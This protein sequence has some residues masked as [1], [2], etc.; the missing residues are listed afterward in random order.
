MTLTIE[1][2]GELGVLSGDL[3]SNVF[4]VA[5][6]MPGRKRWKERELHFELTR[7]NID[8]MR[9][10]LPEAEWKESARFKQVIDAEHLERDAREAK[11]RDAP[12]EAS[13]FQF[14][15]QPRDHQRKTFELSKD[16]P[17]FGY[18][19][20][21]GLG[22]TKIAIDVAAHLYANGKIDTMLITAPNGVHRQWVNEQLPAHMPDFIKT[23]A[24]IYQSNHTKKWLKE[25]NDTV[26]YQDGLR[27]FAFH[28]EAFQS[29]KGVSFARIALDTGRAIWHLDESVAIKTPGAKRTKNILKLAPLAPYRRILSGAPV[30]KGIED[31]F[32]QFKFLNE[33]I[34]GFRS[35]YTFRNYYCETA[36]IPGAPAGAVRIVGYK[37]VDELQQQIDAWSVRYEA[38]DCLDLPERVYKT[39]EV[40]WDKKQQKIYTDL[41][42]D[43]LA[44][45]GDGTLVTA[46]Q[47]IVR[48]LR[49]QQVLCGHTKDSEGNVIEVP[50]NRIKTVTEIM[51]EV[52]DK[53][54]IWA[55][56]HKDIDM[57][58]DALKEY[59]PVTWDG[60]T[61]DADRDAAKKAFIN[62]DDVRVFIGNPSAAGTGLDGL[63]HA[64]HTMIYY[65]NSFDASDR[66]QSEARL[67]RDGQ[68]GTVTVIDL[69]V[70]GTIDTHIR[71]ALRDKKT[72]SDMAFAID[73][74]T[75]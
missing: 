59:R 16:A 55:R 18:F 14:K 43:L 6:E 27:V 47:I 63:Q 37:N 30:T 49:L 66:W 51:E 62:D 20:E 22:K 50:T 8:F 19:L 72:V 45:I 58:R 25:W 24:V 68:R 71:R 39:V 60:R 26:E 4:E 5:R 36:P 40:E 65:S 46:E 64:S 13:Y 44:E 1:Q 2:R 61:S 23:R 57:L 75:V 15:T 70:P 52:S 11:K 54:L 38:A 7:A 48:M 10:R 34:L 21:M 73:A 9:N 67:F 32:T 12:P 42:D 29:D 41:R 33:D 74:E 3:N 28:R 35:F 31:L 53:V 69:E 56:F 17:V